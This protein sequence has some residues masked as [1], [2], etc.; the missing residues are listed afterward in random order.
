[1]QSL[2]RFELLGSVGMG[3]FGTVYKA[4]DPELDRIVAIKVPR[5]GSL[6]SGPELDRFLREARSAA[7]LR[8]PS[9]VSVHEVGQAEGMPYLVSDFVHGITLADSL[10]A[11]R[12][13]FQEAARLVAHLAQVL[14]YAHDQGVVHRDVKPSNIMLDEKGQAHLMDFGLAKREAGDVTMTLEG[15]VLGTP[16][17][18]SPE[19]AR[20]QAH[21]VD[22]RSD[23]YSLGVILYQLLT[24]VLPFRGNT[25][26]LLHQV[27]HD[28]PR[29]P[30]S[31]DRRIPRD[32]QTICLKAMAKEPDRRYATA[33]ELADDL[34]WYLAGEPIRARPA[35]RW[36]RA[37][38][39]ARRR[40]AAALLALN[41]VA[42][43]AVLGYLLSTWQASPRVVDA[44]Q[45]NGSTAADSS[46]ARV[47]TSRG[48]QKTYERVAMPKESPHI[49]L[50]SEA[51]Y[52]RLL[53]ST[54]WLAVRLARHLSATGTA[55]VVDE[56]NKLI[57][58]NNHLFLSAE[59]KELKVMA[60]FPAE[61]SGKIIAER[62]IFVRK[63]AE[64]KGIAGQV[65]YQD[66]Q[67]DLA[68][69]QLES[70]P[71]WVP[72]LP[73]AQVSGRSGETVHS[74]GNPGA[75]ET[76]W[77]YSTG[78]IRSAH[79]K[80]WKVR[81]EDQVL[82]FEANVLET[83]APVNPGDSGGPLVNDRAELLALTYGTGAD[84][85]LLS[86]FIDASEIRY[87]LS[88]YYKQSGKRPPR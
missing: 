77:V 88:C 16:A 58:T 78:T 22:G 67:R 6:G 8:H 10:T 19:Q 41:G 14:Q 59:P 81:S 87:V 13:G 17:Y 76:M 63:L 31:L 79:R 64:G 70:L 1:M 54:V 66:A 68:L 9:I 15:Q 72:A 27:L 20:G 62:E 11:G 44:A 51:T 34:N 52:K 26:V 71:F 57:V 86:L 55:F 18:M 5:V 12:P 7:Q 30:R 40:P 85:Q 21:D 29:P 37:I 80:K 53:R 38:K 75:S 82:D 24:G 83:S 28:E 33:R 42:V 56:E 25:R 32:L 74:I 49:P 73:I 4:R 36:E 46:K 35:P 3:A 61:E 2:G 60:I 43:A 50:S 48:D 84:G 65:V 47:A 39:W 23:L 45:T 69:I